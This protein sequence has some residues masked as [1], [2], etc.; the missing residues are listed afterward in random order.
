MA[1][2][3]KNKTRAAI[4]RP[5]SWC[6]KWYYPN[7]PVRLL[8]FHT[9][10]GPALNHGGWNDIRA[11]RWVSIRKANMQQHTRLFTF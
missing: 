9:H 1:T 6:H 5:V 3:R 2:T 11:R 7:S 10:E 8:G 4:M